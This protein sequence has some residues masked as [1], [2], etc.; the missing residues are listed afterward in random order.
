MNVKEA[1]TDK[2][3]KK[4]AKLEAKWTEDHNLKK[5][6]RAELINRSRP[7]EPTKSY[8]GEDRVITFNKRYNYATGRTYVFSAIRP[9]SSNKWF[10]TGKGVGTG[11]G[12]SW[13]ELLDFIADRETDGKKKAWGTIRRYEMKGPITP[14]TGERFLVDPTSFGI[15]KSDIAEGLYV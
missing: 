5:E 12:L 15:N 10:V 1:S 2:L 14:D 11:D 6:I 4:L 3:L 9:W 8:A 7:S 13:S